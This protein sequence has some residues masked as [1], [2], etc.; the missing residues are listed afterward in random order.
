MPGVFNSR[1]HKS[2]DLASLLSDVSW[3]DQVRC[4]VNASGWSVILIV[5]LY[6]FH[7][8]SL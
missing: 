8:N 7:L 2:T 3:L 4:W 1:Q 6:I 5:Q